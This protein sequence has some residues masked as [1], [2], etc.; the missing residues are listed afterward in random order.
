MVIPQPCVNL[1]FGCAFPDVRFWFTLWT[2]H[3]HSRGMGARWPH[4][5]QQ[6]GPTAIWNQ[7]LLGDVDSLSPRR[8]ITCRRGA[9]STR[10]H[11][12]SRASARRRKG[13]RA[14]QTSK[15]ALSLKHSPRTRECLTRTEPFG[16]VKGELNQEAS[17]PLPPY[18][19]SPSPQRAAR[20]ATSHTLVENPRHRHR[21]VGPGL[22]PASHARRT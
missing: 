1:W 13:I 21:R 3:G 12:T 15:T 6:L 9:A 4:L 16:P 5:P 10:P 7:V 2:S 11:G 22:R 19:L 17:E 18:R 14:R 20:V 8:P